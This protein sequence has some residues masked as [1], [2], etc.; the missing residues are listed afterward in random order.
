MK[1]AGRR[2]AECFLRP[3][4]TLL[5][6]RLT[7]P[8]VSFIDRARVALL[9]LGQAEADHDTQLVYYLMQEIR[10]ASSSKKEGNI[11]NFLDLALELG[12]VTKMVQYISHPDQCIQNETVWIYANV[13]AVSSGGCKA[14]LDHGILP[15]IIHC[16]ETSN[17]EDVKDNCIWMIA[18]FAAESPD[19]TRLVLK[20]GF[21]RA[22]I[23]MIRQTSLHTNT[24]QHCCWVISN[25]FRGKELDK[26]VS[27]TDRRVMVDFLIQN[28]SIKE[29][30]TRCEL[31]YSIARMLKNDDQL[32]NYAVSRLNFDTLASLL[33]PSCESVCM[34]AARLVG[35]IST[36][37][38][39]EAQLM[40]DHG[41]LE[42]LVPLLAVKGNDKLRQE[43]LWV[44]SNLAAG[45]SAHKQRI[46]DSGIVDATKEL[47][48]NCKDKK[49]RKEVA[50]VIGNLSSDGT[51]EQCKKLFADGA[52]DMLMM[53]IDDNFDV[54]TQTVLEGIEQLIKRNK[55][56]A[57]D[58][59]KKGY[60]ERIVALQLHPS[61]G[62]FNTVV[63]LL[64]GNFEEED[65][66]EALINVARAPAEPGAVG[67]I[68]GQ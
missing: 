47:L 3:C 54:T 27:Q 31:L 4:L 26:I 18:N 68:S 44:I 48:K 12:L 43:A 6:P 8:Q 66:F 36:G 5:D 59:E 22:F 33:D 62:V 17:D 50:F 56:A 65:E 19:Y 42:K 63:R 57:Q 46:I 35:N 14:L 13:A 51:D 25:V 24:V 58:L 29:E 49:S 7:D 38:N 30:E 53:M 67:R 15:Q 20:G 16:L 21:P 2:Y 60:L 32:R 39:E 52:I 9:L 34:G 40:V 1:R 10:F 45:P 41:I 64:R 61:K 23:D 55:E 37:T 28:F 11:E